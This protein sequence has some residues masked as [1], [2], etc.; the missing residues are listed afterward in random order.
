MC[1]ELKDIGVKLENST[2][3]VELVSHN[4][5]LNPELYLPAIPGV[6]VALAGL[7]IAHCLARS[8]ERR[9]EISDRCDTLRDSAELA[10]ECALAAWA[11]PKGNKRK[12]KIQKTKRKLQI[13]GTIA[14]D[15]AR[16]S[17]SRLRPGVDLA[18]EVTAFRR[19]T[20]A[21]PF[22][23]P[24]RTGTHQR[25]GDVNNALANLLTAITTRFSQRCP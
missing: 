18:Q 3:K 23:D 22:E 2:V 25:D 13:V 24:T 19:A 14:T 7:W 17:K 1:P 11:C 10:A 9:K 20:T 21:D 15:L 12:E 4:S 6:L 5:W 8:R 16:R